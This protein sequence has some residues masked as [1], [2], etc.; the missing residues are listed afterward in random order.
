MY[1]LAENIY[2][3][4]S[5]YHAYR[6]NYIIDNGLK[7]SIFVEDDDLRTSGRPRSPIAPQP[8][9]VNKIEDYEKELLNEKHGAGFSGY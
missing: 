8:Y 5:P 6:G 7:S 9:R 1:T 3:T 2:M 4:G